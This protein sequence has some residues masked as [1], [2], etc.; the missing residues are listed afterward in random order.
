MVLKLDL[1]KA[2]DRM[3]WAF[4]KDTLEVAGIPIHSC[5]SSS[6]MAIN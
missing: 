6:S 5:I 2:Y 1:E 3:E 4:V